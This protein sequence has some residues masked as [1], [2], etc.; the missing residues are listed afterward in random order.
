[1]ISAKRESY[2]TSLH[3][4]VAD[5]STRLRVAQKEAEKAGL[6]VTRA[7]GAG[8]RTLVVTKLVKDG[9]TIWKRS[10]VK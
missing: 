5:L 3:D 7:G 1:M 10:T 8:G 9:I 2:F 6:I 4:E